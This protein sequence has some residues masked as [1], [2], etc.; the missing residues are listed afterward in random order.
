MAVSFESLQEHLVLNI[1]WTLLLFFFAFFV[2][3]SVLVY[4]I[5]EIVALDLLSMCGLMLSILRFLKSIDCFDE[6]NILLCLI[7]TLLFKSSVKIILDFYRTHQNST[8]ENSTDYR[9]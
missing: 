9:S 6:L 8:L 4:L 7:I 3:F 5:F 1:D 2:A